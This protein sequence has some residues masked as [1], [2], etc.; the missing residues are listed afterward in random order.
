[1]TLLQLSA[2]RS[3]AAAASTTARA[4]RS[5]ARRRSLS[6]YRG[7]EPRALSAALPSA[8]ART[9]SSLA[10]TAVASVHEA[11]AESDRVLAIADWALN[12][13]RIEPRSVL[14]K[15]RLEFTLTPELEALTSASAV[16]EE[17]AAETNP[18]ALASASRAYIS[19]AD[20]DKWLQDFEIPQEHLAKCQTHEEVQELRRRYARQ[21]RLECSV[22]E[23]AMDKFK[24]SHLKVRQIGRASNT[25]A[26]KDLIRQWMVPA[27]E[28]IRNEQSR[29][30]AGRHSMDS[31]MYGPALLMLKPDVIAATGL[32][33]MLNQCLG[34][35]KGP[36]FIKLALAMGKAVQEEII[37]QKERVEKRG[38]QDM[39][40]LQRAAM[41]E[42]DIVKAKMRSY[43]DEVGA[44]DKRLQLK[45]GAAVIDCIQRS[46]FIPEAHEK[47]HQRNDE[48]ASKRAAKK[49]EKKPAFLHDYV[50]ER[51]RRAG[52][53]KIHPEIANTVLKTNPGENILPWTARYLPMLVPPTKWTSIVN[54]GYLKL[55]TKIMR[56]RDSAWQMDCVKRGELDPLF[57][58]LNL[59]AEVPW[60]INKKVLNVILAMWNDGGGFGD[61]PSRTDLPLP[62]WKEELAT[63]P[64]Q[65]ETHDK[66]TRKVCA[67]CQCVCMLMHQNQA[68][69]A[70]WEETQSCVCGFKLIVRKQ[71]VLL[72]SAR[73]YPTRWI[74]AF[75]RVD[76]HAVTVCCI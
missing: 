17:L 44:W 40:Y 32:N 66:M 68:R 39:Y 72:G 42:S 71:A 55:H 49:A 12:A 16:T 7:N 10:A 2:A 37:V 8:G 65:R 43:H 20:V 69:H 23:M 59:L 21:L 74:A 36:K 62:E 18:A 38:G 5:I 9:E 29:I 61:L 35:A 70:F 30:R 58:S 67:L 13:E 34:E 28:F 41:V 56:Q 64:A 11:D 19:D 4:A 75:G 48:D 63:D 50:F 26:A 31:N 45:V 54:G 27:Q 15:S 73:C 24:S 60:V 22:Y 76:S 1:M 14:Q 57:K 33:V 51:N 53:I 25:N 47:R 46:C 52:V 6:Y 3:H